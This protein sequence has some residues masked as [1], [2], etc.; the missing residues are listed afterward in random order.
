MKAPS[1][2]IIDSDS[3]L[4]VCAASDQELAAILMLSR[5]WKMID[6]R[7]NGRRTNGWGL[8]L[9]LVA[10]PFAH[11][12][13][14]PIRIDQPHA[15]PSRNEAIKSERSQRNRNLVADPAEERV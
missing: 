2:G 11:L 1:A 9:I 10:I 7:L 8:G 4:Y 5:W 14:H 12:Y 6:T 13:Y 3:G 15:T